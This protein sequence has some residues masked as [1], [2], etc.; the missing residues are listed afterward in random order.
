MDLGGTRQLVVDEESAALNFPGMER[1][2]IERDHVNMCK[3]E[4]E[5][6][7]G[8]ELVAEAIQRYAANA[9]DVISARW[10]QADWERQAEGRH[11]VRERLSGADQGGIAGLPGSPAWSDVVVEDEATEDEGSDVSEVAEE[12]QPYRR[13]GKDQVSKKSSSRLLCWRI[14]ATHTTNKTAELS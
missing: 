2:T 6:D 8:F 1:A 4:S 9:P 11:I 7:P 3:F 5:H 10:Q 13:P 12:E 14:L